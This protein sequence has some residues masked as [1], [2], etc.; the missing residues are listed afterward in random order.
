MD[1]NKYHLSTGMHRNKEVIWIAFEINQQLKMEL[2]KRFPSAKWSQTNKSWYLPDLPSVRTALGMK[3]RELGSRLKK[4]IHP[5][6][7]TAYEA[8]QKQLKLKAYSKHTQSTYLS[9]FA[10]LLGILKGHNVNEL[11]PGR[12][13]DY[14]YYCATQLKMK[15]RKLNGKL[16][17]LKFYF[18]QVLNKPKM[19]LEIPRPK[20]PSTLPKM[21]SKEEV[22]RVFNQVKNPK[23]LLALRLS[24][25]M[26]LRVSELVAIKLEHIDSS[27]KVVLIEGAKG[28]KDRYVN[29]PE[30][31]IQDLRTY[32]K[33]FKPKKWLFEGQYGG[34]YS[35][36]SVQHV[37]KKAMNAAG[38]LK[39]IGV[40]GLRHSYAT[41][42]LESGADIRYIQELLG[43]HSIK[44]TQIY[45]HVT[46]GSKRNVRSPLDDLD[47]A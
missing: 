25:G 7:L 11:T 21:L 1:I 16:N 20:K 10:H 35:T 13:K 8:M 28:K 2:K 43:H 19:F 23:H 31:V 36:S 5:V 4:Y 34:P 9:E 12:L 42:L 33:A 40:H 3:H 22:K 32:Y 44:T 6:N 14:L 26:G 45:T 18:E 15:E 39:K 47:K 24:Y 41:H 38:I 46:P 27:R 17:A 37:F 29:L 30:S